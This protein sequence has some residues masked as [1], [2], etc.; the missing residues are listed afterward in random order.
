M[1][2][3]PIGDDCIVVKTGQGTFHISE[4]QEGTKI[5]MKENFELKAKPGEQPEIRLFG[6]VKIIKEIR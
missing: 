6:E 1:T 4:T 3:N 5:V 2:I